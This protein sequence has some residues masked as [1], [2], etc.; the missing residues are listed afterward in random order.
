MRPE[1]SVAPAFLAGG[2]EMGERIRRHDWA[3]TAL[4]APERWPP[5]LRGALGICLHSS[6]PTAIYWGPELLLLYN[7]AWA[8]VPAD[9]HPWA[10]GRPAREVWADIWPV[11][12]TQFAQVME[13][14]EGVSSFDQMLPMR[15]GDS[16]E[17]TYWNY[18]F[19]PIRDEAGHVV[20]V[21]NQGNET[22]ARLLAERRQGFLLRLSDRLR[23]QSDPQA[24][25]ATAQEELG[26]HLGASR[27]GF[28]EIDAAAR[29]CTTE[30]NWT[31]GSVESHHGTHDLA[32]FG[33]EVLATL[34]RGETLVLHDVATDP[35]SA[36]PQAQGAFAAI[37]SAAV[38]GATLL[39][40]GR[41]RAALYVHSRHP[42]RWRKE[43]VQLVEEV[44]ERSWAAL[45]RARAEAALRESEARFRNV[46]DHAPLM[47]WLTEASGRCTYLNRVW[48]EFTGQTEAEALGF[49]WLEAVHPDDRGWSGQ[50]FRDANARQAPFR[51]EYRLRRADG[52][53]RWAIDAAAPRFGAS[54][55]FLGYVGSVLDIGERRAAEEALR[56]SEARF[57]EVADA[58]PVLIWISDTSKGCTW[59][60]RP[61]LDFTGRSMAEELGHGW[62]EAVHPEDRDRCFATYAAAFEA[63]R[64][65][66]MDYRMRR[67]DG[68]WRVIDDTGVPRFA[69]GGEFLGY[70]G[71]CVDVTEQ[72]ASAA[73]FLGVFNSE[74]MGFTIFDANT[75]ET[76]AAND[77]ILRMVGRSRA[78]F[79]AAGLDWREVTPRDAWA[80]DE[81]AI[82]QARARGWWDPFV[83]E[84]LRRDGSRLPVRLSS[85]PLPGEP[86]RVVIAIEDI[87]DER[88]TQAALSASEERLRLGLAAG[89]MVTWEYDLPSGTILRSA[90]AEEVFGA[91]ERPEDFN[92]RLPEADAAANAKR[93]QDVIE[94]RSETYQSDFRYRHP[95]GQWMWL[96]NQGRV[97]R[98][99]DGRPLRVN[100]VC[101]DITAR[102]EIEQALAARE[103]E[104]RRLNTR[105]EERVREEVAAR[106]AAQAQLAHAQRMEALGQLAGGIAHDFNNVLQAVQGG[107]RLIEQAPQD[108]GRVHRLA[109]MI[110]EAAGRGANVTRRLLA[111]SRRADLRAEPVN[112]AELLRGLQDVLAHTLGG[113]IRVELALAPAMPLLLADKGQLETAL[114]NLAANARDAMSGQGTIALAAAP[115]A[116]GT[117]PEGLEPGRYLLLSVADTGIGMRP[118]VLARASEPFFTTK[119]VGKG[120]GL[121]LAMARGFAEQTGGAM[122]IESEPGRGTTV[123]LWLP[124]TD[125][126]PAAEVP[127]G[128][129][130]E[131]VRSG[132]RG[133][134]VLVDDE[135][136]VRRITAESLQSAGFAVLMAGSGEEALRLLDTGAPVDVLVSDLSMP[137]MD[138]LALIRE[139]QQRRPA[140]PAILLTG[141]A[142]DVAELAV[143]GA[144]SGSFSLLRKPVEGEALAERVAVLLQGIDAGR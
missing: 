101:I 25:I 136:L 141:F 31:D 88:A 45:E 127:V 20:G 53:Y 113:G 132:D 103:A 104:L 92:A 100:G 143:S 26:R 83:K 138:G 29:H 93:L 102:K 76:L 51:L 118:E 65:F 109:A 32:C 105:L 73:R 106:I 23:G 78:E 97:Q 72:R 3:G 99:A 5:A 35:R 142:T 37:E 33:A 80:Q 129:P 34:R 71:S 107:A 64:P 56:E 7:D 130:P 117:L 24:V 17:E 1:A 14:G 89:R 27:V 98:D 43:E 62:V 41:M 87:S 139:A 94:G 110:A 59:F 90:N 128:G 115:A 19:T 124:V 38:I 69:E 12:A 82:A 58:A 13:R 96:H 46:A 39:K 123:S 86:G 9:R 49:G 22:T 81:A 74:L 116:E 11:V 18:S 131:A 111:F 112:A 63:R 134:V 77:V 4:G 55:E 70:I 54:G 120:T 66:R 67:H 119:P 47:M 6:F 28:G 125:A 15:R 75:G 2:G 85:A 30:S 36:G 91:G 133:R 60:N 137:G 122:R 48:Y 57:R 16:I 52:T 8:P 114:V 84:M 68:A 108:P 126:L 40:E 50:T 21:F 79:E 121:G 140:M 135:E 144:I 10:L 42:R 61:W 95:N 44:A